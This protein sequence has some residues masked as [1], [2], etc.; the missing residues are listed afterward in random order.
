MA[1]TKKVVAAGTKYT[2]W[3][4]LDTDGYFIGSGAT[5]PA[6]GNQDGSGMARLEGTKNVPIR[7]GDVVTVPV[8]GDDETLAIFA[9]DNEDLPN[10]TL[11]TAV[12]DMD[13]EAACLGLTLQEIGN[14]AFLPSGAPKDANRTTMCMIVQGRAKSRVSGSV[15]NSRYQGVVI[16]TA[17]MVP[18]GR[19][20]FQERAAGAYDYSITMNKGDRM[21]WGATLS[22]SL[23]GTEQAAY[24]V[25][26]LGN[27]L[28]A[29]RWT[30]DASE[31]V[32]NLPY[33][34]AGTSLT[35]EVLVFV[36]GVRVLSG[37]TVSATGKT[38][39]WGSAPANNARLTCLYEFSV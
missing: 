17:T 5:A 10:G 39:T 4:R 20:A 15:G 18:L 13:F 24:G 29:M 21:P 31:T 19:D 25:F 16:P 11:Q 7:Q 30:G 22:D 34:P 1:T 14:L 33:T 23:N 12:L 9:F 36:E 2:F 38:L 37:V 3:G 27:P 32:F 28:H 8:T 26:T 35:A 6:A